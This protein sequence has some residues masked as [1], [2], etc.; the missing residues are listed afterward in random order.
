MQRVIIVPGWGE[1]PTA[2]EAADT[3]RREEVNH[4]FQ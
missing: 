2:H 4:S 1:R 3:E